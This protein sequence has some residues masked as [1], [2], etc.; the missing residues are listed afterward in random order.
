MYRCLE[1]KE[2]KRGSARERSRRRGK[3]G[4]ARVELICSSPPCFRSF[5]FW[6]K[7]LTRKIV[8]LSVGR[9]GCERKTR[10]EGDSGTVGLAV[11]DRRHGWRGGRSGSVEFGR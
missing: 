8:T 5:L 9:L 3:E 6:Q 11:D 1:I 10:L 2:K 4:R 7:K